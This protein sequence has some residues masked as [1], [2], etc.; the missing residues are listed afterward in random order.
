MAQIC[1]RQTATKFKFLLKGI[2]T[3]M[4]FDSI[5]KSLINALEQNGVKEYEVYYFSSKG[6]SVD[7]LNNEIN[8]FSDGTTGGIC[9]RIVAN[10]KIGYASSELMSDAEMQSLVY[11]ALENAKYIEKE[12]TVGLFAGS[13][14]YETPNCKKYV[15]LET[16]RLK[17]LAVDI[18]NK[19]YAYSDKIKD[20]TSSSA[21]ASEFSIRLFN[22]YGLDLEN[23]CGVNGTLAEAVVCDNDEYESAYKVKEYCEGLDTE[24]IAQ[25]AINDALG[26][27]G[28]GLVS[29]GKYNVIIDGKQMRAILSAFSSAFSS[30]NAQMGLSL[31][32]GKE[33]EVIAS[34]IVTITDDPM[35]EGVSIQT[36][37]DG[38]GVATHRKNII[39][40]GVL[41]TLLYNRETALKAGKETTANA[42]KGSYA[43]PIGISPYAFCIE[44]GDKTLDELFNLAENGIYVTAVKGLHAGANAVTGDFSIESAGFLIKDGKKAEAVK[45]FT[46]AGNFFELLKSIAAL[47]DT[48]EMGVPS[49][50]TTFGSPAVLIKDMSVAGK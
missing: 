9:L 45:S 25:S 23:H 22:S 24:E 34:D 7:T 1:H 27:I 3:K 50:F 4:N 48:I 49:G 28:S 32:A 36:H 37:F 18:A 21:F 15:P 33:G 44:A 14:H 13:D 43:A 16:A 29:T 26:K 30:K 10:G 2:F 35:R 8:A 39:E 11:R 6:T 46:I 38:E 17:S 5:K 40:N 31:L 12:D 47:S 41:K 42:S 19:M 20:G